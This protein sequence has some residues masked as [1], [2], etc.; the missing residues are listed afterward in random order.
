MKSPEL[1]TLK[2]VVERLDN[3][4]IPYMLT[5]SMALNF[6][7]HPRATNDFDIVIEVSRKDED[8]LLKL[9]QDGFYITREAVHEA[10]SAGRMF[11]IMDEES[12]FKVDLIVKKNDPFSKMQFSRRQPKEFEGIRIN[13]ISPEDLILSKLEWSRESLSEMQERDIK[14]LMTLLAKELDYPYMEQWAIRIGCLERLK[15]FYV[16]V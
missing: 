14:N 12:I 8:R 4:S 6:Y 9:F 15:G 7:S 2:R 1:K 11:N 5:G 3:A 13:V 16:S 10:L